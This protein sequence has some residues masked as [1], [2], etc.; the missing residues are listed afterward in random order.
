MTAKAALNKH[1]H[2]LQ[3]KYNRLSHRDQLALTLLS[4]FFSILIL[5]YGIWL[6]TLNHHKDARNHWQ[7]QQQLLSWLQAQENVIPKASTTRAQSNS[8]QPLLTRVTNSAKKKNLTLKRVQP[9]EDNKLRVWM[10]NV[11]FNQTIVWL[12]QLNQNLGLSIADI[13]IDG[14]QQQN[15][16]VNVRILITE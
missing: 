1:I 7:Q 9:E 10:E 16:I 13:A 3:Q 11:N 12:E 15:G 4:I 8:Q 2:D 5:I 6:P 14:Q